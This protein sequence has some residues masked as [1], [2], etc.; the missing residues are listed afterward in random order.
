MILNIS[1]VHG[2]GGIKVDTN[3]SWTVEDIKEMS[4][5]GN[6]FS[7]YSFGFSDKTY[8][9]KLNLSR[10][11]GDILQVTSAELDTV[12]VFFLRKHEVIDSS[13]YGL[14]LPFE[15]RKLANRY[16]S[17]DIPEGADQAII[18]INSGIKVD[19]QLRIIER[20][21]YQK[22][23][24]IDLVLFSILHGIILLVLLYN[25]VLFLQL[26]ESIYGYYSFYLVSLFLS[27]LAITGFGNQFFFPRLGALN[28]AHIDLAVSCMLISFSLFTTQVLKFK[29]Y[30][31]SLNK[32]FLVISGIGVFFF[33]GSFVFELRSIIVKGLHLFP[34]IAMLLAFVGAVK[35]YRKGLKSAKFYL[36]GW[37]CFFFGA[38][39]LQLKGWAFFP[40]STFVDNFNFFGAALE[41]LF[42]SFTI[43][44]QMKLYKKEIDEKNN[45]VIFFEKEMILLREQLSYPETGKVK[46]SV[47]NQELNTY[48][49]SPLS[50]REMDVLTL[51]T[52]GKKNQEVA[53]ELF[54]S[55]NTVKTHIRNIY[56]KLDVKNRT[57]AL[58]KA[59]KFDIIR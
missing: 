24:I 58:K 33:F 7:R 30:S 20:K 55:V 34:A 48:L 46:Y 10:T 32:I 4:F 59:Q 12:R 13:T 3:N 52:E 25:I 38:M 29:F 35:V 54:V 6:P 28:Y 1:S 14:L 57:E 15:D 41:T 2:E 19:F 50:D 53:D 26:K 11:Q 18:K 44:S 40:H 49:L 31:P 47:S 36:F 16:P 5:Q 39:M 8:W 21:K 17:F 27:A 23:F 42:F 45:K 51:L 22:N 9:L 56:E 37:T 43:S